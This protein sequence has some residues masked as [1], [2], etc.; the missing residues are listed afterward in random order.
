MKYSTSLLFLFLLFEINCFTQIIDS[1]ATTI[2]TRFS[3]PDG[4]V[5]QKQTG[6]SN[7]LRHLPLK[8]TAA[9]VHYYNGQE[10][11]NNVYAAVI[12][13]DVGTRDLQQCA[14]AIMRLRAEYLYSIKDYHKI[15]FNFTNG[16]RCNY[17]EWMKGKRILVNGN[18]VTWVQKHQPSNNY[19]DFRNYLTIIFSYA[20]TL[21]LD[22]ELKP[23]SIED[24]QIGDVFIQG[25]SPGHAI[26]VVD[27]AISRVTNEKV[28]LLVQSYMPAQDIHVLKNFA[29]KDNNPWYSIPKNGVL[30]TPEWTFETGDLKRF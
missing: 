30:N 19:K 5:R 21:S 22:K 3:P 15:H 16:F 18:K 10:K 2:Q 8:S 25:G 6:F 28:F 7:Y 1:S 4:F 24:L 29:N 11:S 13:I 27:V 26:I 23:V 12:D 20:G 17:S 9:K 14:D